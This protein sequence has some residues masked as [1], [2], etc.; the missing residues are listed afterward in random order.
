MGIGGVCRNSKKIV[1]GKAAACLK[2]LRVGSMAL[3]LDDHPNVERPV[4]EAALGLKS[5][6]FK[7]TQIDASNYLPTT[8][9]AVLVTQI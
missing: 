3:P 9:Y 7:S 5:K 6:S 1:A 4:R 8:L 2:A